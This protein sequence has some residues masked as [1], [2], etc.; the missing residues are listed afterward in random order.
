M[1]Q[2]RKQRLIMKNVTARISKIFVLFGIVSC[3]SGPD[4][5]FINSQNDLWHI[6]QNGQFRTDSSTLFLRFKKNGKYEDLTKIGDDFKSTESHPDILNYHKWKVLNDSVVSIAS[7]K[8]RINISNEDSI[9][10][11]NIK[12]IQDTLLLKKHYLP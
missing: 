2:K 8:Y 1:V 4:R 11:F 7:I 12:R 9:R 10:L 5:I 3:Q 6:V